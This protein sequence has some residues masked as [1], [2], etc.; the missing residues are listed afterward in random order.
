M[1]VVGQVTR[2]VIGEGPILR[3][4]LAEGLDRVR[5]FVDGADPLSVF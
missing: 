5:Q 4:W 2:A 1:K 3:G